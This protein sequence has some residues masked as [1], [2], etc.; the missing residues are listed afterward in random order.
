MPPFA[1]PDA[2][3]QQL[4]AFIRSLSTKAAQLTVS[5]NLASGNEIFFGKGGCSGCH[6]IRGQGGLLGPDLSNIGGERTLGE[7]R[8][9]ILNPNQSMQPKFQAVTVVTKDGEK[10]SGT[11]RNRDN[12]SLQ[13]MAA[14]GTFRFFVSSELRETV[15]QKTSAMPGNYEKLLD[16]SELQDLLAFLSRQTVVN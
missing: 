9:S 14:D 16:A 8:L 3:V 15:F 12:F 10:V 11:L 13:M 6:M 5:G 4:V 1:L 7:I 2:D